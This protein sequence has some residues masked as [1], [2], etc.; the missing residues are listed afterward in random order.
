MS[1]G[2]TRKFVTLTQGSDMGQNFQIIN[3]CALVKAMFLIVT[4]SLCCKILRFTRKWRLQFNI[5]LWLHT[6]WHNITF[7]FVHEGFFLI[8]FSQFKLL[9]D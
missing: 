5:N 7:N 3:L 6:Y 4:N 9:V 1:C 8:L 2:E